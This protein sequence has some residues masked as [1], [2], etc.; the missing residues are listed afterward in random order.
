MFNPQRQ[1]VD[2]KLVTIDFKYKRKYCQI[3]YIAVS[4]NI[5][6]RHAF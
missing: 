6:Y 5:S 1:I 2:I 4:I 3:N